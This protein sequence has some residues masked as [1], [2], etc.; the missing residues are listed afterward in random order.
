MG[1]YALGKYCQRGSR[2]A[3]MGMESYSTPGIWPRP[4]GICKSQENNS[5][6]RT[7]MNCLYR[8]SY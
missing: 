2:A 1:S 8:K 4:E 5:K 6:H 7:A 3:I